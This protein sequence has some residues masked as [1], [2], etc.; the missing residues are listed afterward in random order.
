MRNGGTAT[1]DAHM[2]PQITIPYISN[3]K[4]GKINT[5]ANLVDGK[6]GKPRP[7]TYPINGLC[8]LTGFSRLARGVVL[9][10]F[11]NQR[12][13]PLDNLS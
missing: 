4:C 2:I 1:V 13:T 12:L 5:L 7:S 10:A 3:V 9:K 11:R 8:V 6:L